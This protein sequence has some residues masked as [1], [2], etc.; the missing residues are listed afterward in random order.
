VASSGAAARI[1]F[2]DKR[3]PS[4]SNAAPDAV[5]RSP[6]LGVSPITGLDRKAVRT[7]RGRISSDCAAI[8]DI[9]RHAFQLAAMKTDASAR[10]L[11]RLSRLGAVLSAAIALS[12]CGL[13]AHTGA[14]SSGS[15]PGIVG[16]KGVS[17]QPS[18]S[19]RGP[20][21]FPLGVVM[22]RTS[23][24]GGPPDGFQVA[25]VGID[26][27]VRATASGR[28]PHLFPWYPEV[29]VAGSRVFFMDGDDQLKVLALDGRVSDV[30]RLPGG[31]DHRMVVAVD[32][33]TGRIAYGDDSID[34][35]TCPSPPNRDSPPCSPAVSTNLFISGADGTGSRQLPVHQ[36]PIGWHD[37]QI[38]AEPGAGNIQ[39][40]GQINPYVVHDLA[41]VDPATGAVRRIGARCAYPDGSF[42]GPLSPAGMACAHQL[43]YIGAIG[44]DGTERRVTAGPL[45]PDSSPAPLSPDGSTVALP[46]QGELFTSTAGG[47]KDVGVRAVPYGWFDQGHLLA[48]TSPQEATANGLEV[49]DLSTG[50]T[51][52]LDLHP[53][54]MTFIPPYGAFFSQL[55]VAR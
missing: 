53:N 6:E 14:G 4:L 19:Q 18:T 41:L 27:R 26:G 16:A 46:V 42:T 34:P 39:N 11:Y 37:G 29:S 23:S 17:P 31:P 10:R 50:R 1:D 49:V 3:A 13:G 2:F 24:S 35:T 47:S 44:W 54:G 15:T 45:R 25:I 55:P 12:G 5:Q 43:S 51:V 9:R 40:E 21:G 36:L 7:L 48:S 33:Q 30:A 22:F 32:P 28:L 52:A 8:T 20:A 38:V